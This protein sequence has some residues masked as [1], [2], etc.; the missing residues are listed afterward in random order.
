MQPSRTPFPKRLSLGLTTRCNLDCAFCARAA[1]TANNHLADV[2]ME[3][4][5]ALGGVI[6]GAERILLCGYGEP[7]LHRQ[8]RELLEL[9]YARNP[10]TQLIEITTNG[11]RLN[12][13]TAA[14]FAGRVGRLMISLNA[15]DRESYAREMFPRPTAAGR[16]MGFTFDRLVEGLR[17]FCDTLA[18]GDRA[19]VELHGVFQRQ[20][21]GG[22]ARFV[23]LA[24]EL[25]IPTV[26]LKH[27][28]VGDIERTDSALIWV[29]HAYNREVDRAVARGDALGVKV[30]MRKFHTEPPPRASAFENC[31][32]MWDTALVN[33]D[34]S[35]HACS[36][37]A[38]AVGHMNEN[39]LE[40]IWEGPGFR[41]LRSGVP[42]K[43]C[44][45]CHSVRDFDDFH[46]HFGYRLTLW[47]PY[48]DR[49][50]ALKREVGRVGRVATAFKS[51]GVDLDQV[52]AA[53]DL[54]ADASA[55]LEQLELSDDPPATAE[56]RVTAILRE[57]LPAFS[58]DTIRLSRPFAGFGWG[59]PSPT[60]GDQGH[61]RRMGGGT[62]NPRLFLRFPDSR[63]RAL[64]SHIFD[65]PGEL[66]RFHV[67]INGVRPECQALQWVSTDRLEHHAFVASDVISA[68]GGFVTV[69]FDLQRP[70]T[71]V[72]DGGWAIGDIKVE[73]AHQC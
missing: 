13:D 10:R 8:F 9:I 52:R 31:S 62:H 58:G 43:A 63:P 16:D 3:R 57:H 18:E 27:E 70:P 29:A 23:E 15:A 51:S 72:M 46:T 28:V 66:D 42:S 4:F 26:W 5:E 64:R 12:G 71:G 53:I 22:M 47:E 55:E 33:T 30:F 48:A 56:K 41:A 67:R 44:R 2:P 59:S 65:A 37:G 35:V 25:N 20:T 1:F 6:A 38:P 14:W 34:G 39:T 69:E 54:H 21:F 36:N 32:A 24:A 50:E 68:G 73:P 11:T 60:Y 40:E 45:M 7:M 49:L 61:W 17:Q 19:A